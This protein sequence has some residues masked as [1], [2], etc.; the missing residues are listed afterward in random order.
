MAIHGINFNF[1][2]RVEDHIENKTNFLDIKYLNLKP[3][4]LPKTK[5]MTE[6]P[7]LFTELFTESIERED[8]E[9]FKRVTI[10]EIEDYLITHGFMETDYI[11]DCT[12]KGFN[13]NFTIDC[14]HLINS[15]VKEYLT[16]NK[17]TYTVINTNELIVENMVIT[18]Y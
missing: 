13:I 11:I 12:Y 4:I 2:F 16:V 1:D 14:A 17:F 18:R 5:Y 8:S 7:E 6:S 9:Y 15:I 10:T 3:I